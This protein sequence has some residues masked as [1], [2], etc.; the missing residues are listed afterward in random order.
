MSK[1]ARQ[2][3]EKLAERGMT[4]ADSQMTEGL[5]R[6][7]YG[8][9]FDESKHKRDEEGKFAAQEA[10]GKAHEATKATAPGSHHQSSQAALQRSQRGE[11]DF[12]A[13]NHKA[14][15]EKHRHLAKQA[16]GGNAPSLADRDLNTKA[17]EAHELAAKLHSGGAGVGNESSDM[18]SRPRRSA[19]SDANPAE[20]SKKAHAASE[21]ANRENTPESHKAARQA[22]IVAARHYEFNSPEHIEHSAKAHEHEDKLAGG[23]QQ[24]PADTESPTPPEPP[25]ANGRVPRRYP[26]E[27]LRSAN[28]GYGFHGETYR[29]MERLGIPEQHR[30]E[31]AHQKFMQMASEIAQAFNIKPEVARDFLD[32][33]MGRHFGDAFY[34]GRDTTGLARKSVIST[35]GNEAKAQKFFEQLAEGTAPGLMQIPETKPGQ[36]SHERRFGP[37]K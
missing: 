24:P 11:S 6:A 26:P 13:N 28:E 18:E 29:H 35:F 12:A 9:A 23:G 19:P 31:Q 17:A 14:T 8:A 15:A 34:G 7:F 16:A 20:A 36:S 32:S 21:I 25:S 3:T 1:T 5:Q 27:A 37:K 4:H 33:R 2:L 10:S 22:H 30:N